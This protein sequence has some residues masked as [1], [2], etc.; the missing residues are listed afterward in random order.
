MIYEDWNTSDYDRWFE[1]KPEN[2]D[3]PTPL[4]HPTGAGSSDAWSGGT[5]EVPTSMRSVDAQ[6]KVRILGTYG[7]Y[8]DNERGNNDA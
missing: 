4:M 7:G 5:F 1:L 2:F 8:G 6:C 3:P